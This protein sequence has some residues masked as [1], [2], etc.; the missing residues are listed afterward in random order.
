M[1]HLTGSIDIRNCCNNALFLNQEKIM[2]HV[3]IKR[4]ARNFL[5]LS[6]QKNITATLRLVTIGKFE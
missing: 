3:T 4:F 5:E 6:I 1:S 2:K